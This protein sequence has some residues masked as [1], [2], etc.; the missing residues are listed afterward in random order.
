MDAQF[1]TAKSILSVVSVS[2]FSPQSPVPSAFT[3]N[4]ETFLVTVSSQHHISLPYLLF[5]ISIFSLFSA[6]EYPTAQTAF[7]SS[8]SCIINPLIYPSGVSYTATLILL[9]S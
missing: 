7:L 2:E 6:D 9:M 3:E 1:L 4:S 8:S 5:R